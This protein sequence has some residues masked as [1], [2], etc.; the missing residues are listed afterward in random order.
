MV[1]LGP[2]GNYKALNLLDS[3]ERYTTYYII[4][5]ECEG[6]NVLALCRELDFKIFY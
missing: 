2:S 3:D 4:L 6:E 5:G 1:A